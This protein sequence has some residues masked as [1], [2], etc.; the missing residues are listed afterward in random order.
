MNNGI[1][2]VRGSDDPWSMGYVHG[3]TGKVQSS[4]HPK[5]VS[6]YDYGQ[7][8]VAARKANGLEATRLHGNRWAVRPTGQL[9]TMGWHPYAWTVIY[10]T[11]KDAH[12]ALV[13]ARRSLEKG[14]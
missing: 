1:A 13:K 8:M 14:A 2:V 10:V 7:K 3:L 12:A 5:Y 4:T 9:G 6:G 11:A